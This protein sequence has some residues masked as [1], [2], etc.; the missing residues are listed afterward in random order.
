M[1]TVR[2]AQADY[3]YIFL[4]LTGPLWFLVRAGGCMGNALQRKIGHFQLLLDATAMVPNKYNTSFGSLFLHLTKTLRISKL[5]WCDHV[6]TSSHLLR[7]VCTAQHW[8]GHGSANNWETPCPRHRQVL[9]LSAIAREMQPWSIV[10]AHK[11]VVTG[12]YWGMTRT[13]LTI[14]ERSPCLPVYKYIH[15]SVC[16]YIYRKRIDSYQIPWLP[17]LSFELP[18][19][20]F[21]KS[22]RKWSK[23]FCCQSAWPFLNWRIDQKPWHD[24]IAMHLQSQVLSRTQGLAHGFQPSMTTLALVTYH[25]AIA[26][27]LSTYASQAF[28]HEWHVLKGRKHEIQ[29]QSVHLPWAVCCWNSKIMS[30]F[31]ALPFKENKN[32]ASNNRFTVHPSSLHQLHLQLSRQLRRRRLDQQ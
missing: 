19:R 21:W 3:K 11:L 32:S 9:A 24:V 4:T 23:T 7:M 26:G 15:I 2:Q 29:S 31:L 27:T 17:R 25:I 14:C 10:N 5:L 16:I 22:R 1:G 20:S 12:L 6:C 13:K 28:P 8:H 18:R 30:C